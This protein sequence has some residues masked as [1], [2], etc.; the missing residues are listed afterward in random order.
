LIP[1]IRSILQVAKDIMLPDLLPGGVEARK[2]LIRRLDKGSN[3][4]KKGMRN[5]TKNKK[6]IDQVN[7][8]IKQAEDEAKSSESLNWIFNRKDKPKRQ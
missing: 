2:H 3:R 6:K 4:L 7:K 1:I 5:S 8:M